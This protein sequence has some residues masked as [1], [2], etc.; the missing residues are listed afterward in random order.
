VRKRTQARELALKALYQKD[1]RGEL[2]PD[3]LQ[4]LREISGCPLDSQPFG[5]QL[6]EG[7]IQAREQIDRMIEETAENWRLDRMP[8]VDRNILRMAT[9]ELVLRRDT[10]PKVVI[11]E[12]IDLAKKFSTEN[13]GAYVNGV[14]DRI[15]NQY[16]PERLEESGAEEE[17]GETGGESR[18]P[19]DWETSAAPAQAGADAR[20][21]W[22]AVPP[23]ATGRADMHV[24]STASDGSLA[25]EEVVRLAARSGLAAVGLTDHDAVDGLRPAEQAAREAG[26]LLVPGVELSAYRTAEEGGEEREL[27]I[28]G[29]FIEP[30]DSRLRRELDRMRRVRS[31]R[32]TRI[33]DKLRELGIPIDPEALVRRAAGGSIGRAHVAQELVR[34][35]CCESVQEA[36]DRYLGT[37][38]PAYV[39][40]ERLTPE[41]A[42]D[43]IHAAGGCAVLAHPGLLPE[44]VD[45]TEELGGAGLDGVEVYYPG[46]TPQMEEALRD[47]AGRLKLVETGGSDF[48]GDSKPHIRVGQET[49]A[50]SAVG[51]LARRSARH[52]RPNVPRAV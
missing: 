15:L 12:A 16:A 7:C 47:V 34:L 4:A 30:G 6:V 11:N 13:S 5:M 52:N 19:A 8:T 51:E 17:E 3:S 23:D 44:G 14:L 28:L 2:P 49:V 21:A 50:L 9:Y 1:V 35:G 25:P 24:H 29:Y 38:G 32:I 45:L 43:L 40:K 10:P 20:D 37:G 33:A 36:F 22:L 31:E 27:H 41:Q 42:I 48:H 18:P 39:P 26:I 46:H